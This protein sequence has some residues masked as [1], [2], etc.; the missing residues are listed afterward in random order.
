M[1]MHRSIHHIAGSPL[2]SVLCRDRRIEVIAFRIANMGQ[3]IA[4]KFCCPSV[5]AV[6]IEP[7]QQV[8]P[9]VDEGIMFTL[10]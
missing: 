4:A 7:I 6:C 10:A 8:S 2:G 3:N 1:S 9:I 5:H